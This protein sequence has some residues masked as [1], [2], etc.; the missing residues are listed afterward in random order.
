[1]TLEKFESQ[2]MDD[3]LHAIRNIAHFLT[4]IQSVVSDMDLIQ[5]TLNALGSYYDGFVDALTHMPGMLTFDDVRNKLLVHEFSFS[6]CRN[7]G[8]LA[9]CT[10][11]SSNH[12]SNFQESA[13]NQGRGKNNR[14]IHGK[15]NRNSRGKN[16]SNK[17]TSQTTSSNKGVP[18]GSVFVIRFVIISHLICFCL[19]HSL[20]ISRY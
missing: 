15:N 9:H 13:S 14:T 6:K 20:F 3:F 12:G 10:S 1:M 16:K 17:A 11:I 19:Y 4:A 2:S 8:S 5:Y 7:N 18:I